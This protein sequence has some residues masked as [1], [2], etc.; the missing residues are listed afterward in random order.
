M[1]IKTVK[2]VIGRRKSL[3]GQNAMIPRETD[4]YGGDRILPPY[5][6]GRIAK[7]S[8]SKKKFQQFYL[9]LSVLY[10]F[11]SLAFG[12]ELL[13]PKINEELLVVG[14]KYSELLLRSGIG[15]F[16]IYSSDYFGKKADK[17]INKNPEDGRIGKIGKSS[18]VT[19][20]Q[21]AFSDEHSY[22]KYLFPLSGE[23]LFD[24]RIQLT[25]F[26]P[27]RITVR[28]KFDLPPFEDPRDW[29]MRY[30]RQK[31]SDFLLT[32]KKQGKL[33]IIG[34][35]KIDEIPCYVAEVPDPSLQDAV[36]KFWIAPKEGFQCLQILRISNSEEILR[37]IK[38]R[39]Y[40]LGEGKIVWFPKS[41]WV[42]LK[43]GRESYRNEMEVT[44]F[45]PNVDVTS[46][47]DLQ[48]P[49]DAKVWNVDLRRWF[50]FKELGWR[51]IEKK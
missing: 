48:I 23:I 34:T 47:F 16:K 28:S 11:S 21:F 41:G 35:E 46:L 43:R 14:L 30:K 50:T 39:R 13:L 37:R 29:G 32:Q 7:M 1:T 44:D 36:L 15:H 20:L 5:F 31:L 51:G 19:E 10:G 2:F 6:T 9:L 40:Q 45:Q 42:I 17:K 24:G 3:T 33:R 12:E 18:S 25:I 27:G 22:F 38:W 8:K 49:P 4:L 26:H